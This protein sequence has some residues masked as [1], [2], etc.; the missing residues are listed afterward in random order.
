[1]H[2]EFLRETEMPQEVNAEKRINIMAINPQIESEETSQSSQGHH[3][4]LKKNRPL[5]PR[6]RSQ[7]SL[8]S[9]LWASIPLAQ[10]RKRT[11]M[12]ELAFLTLLTA[13]AKQ[14]ATLRR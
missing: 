8:T 14:V 12:R 5:P 4:D 2:T 7:E 6:R 11:A 9:L 1:M 13:I 3:R 10:L